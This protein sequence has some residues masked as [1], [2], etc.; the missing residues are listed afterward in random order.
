[1]LFQ[2]IHRIIMDDIDVMYLTVKTDKY[3]IK[4][5]IFINNKMNQ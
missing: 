5:I 4:Y 2:Y 1:M 3:S